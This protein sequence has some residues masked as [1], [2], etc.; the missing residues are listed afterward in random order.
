MEL[1]AGTSAGIDTA[2]STAGC[3]GV[4]IPEGAGP[5]LD[6]LL[7]VS[8]TGFM[9]ADA[10]DVGR[11]DNC[12]ISVPT[13]SGELVPFC[14]YNMTTED[15]E[16]AIRNRNGWGGRTGVDEP[17]PDAPDADEGTVVTPDGVTGTIETDGG[18]DCRGGDDCCGDR[19]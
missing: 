14:A 15:G 19:G 18:D 6:R 13:P 5:L 10:A 9:D 16:Y 11:L 1:L 4:E 7:P 12:C 17:L 2:C 3:C 8:L